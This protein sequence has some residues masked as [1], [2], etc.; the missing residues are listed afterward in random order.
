M[1]YGSICTGVA[2]LDRAVEAVFGALPAWQ[3]EVDK[4]ACKVLARHYP[5]VPNLGDIKTV[6]WSTVE[7]VDILCG[8]PPC[9]PVSQAGL[10]K[11]PDDDRFLWPDVL[12]AVGRLRPRWLVFENPTGFA[13]FLGATLY[14]LAQLGY[15]GSWR[16]LGAADIG[17]CH[18]RDRFFIVAHSSGAGR[19]GDTGDAPAQEEPDRRQPTHGGDFVAGSPDGLSAAHSNGGGCEELGGTSG[20][21]RQTES[22]DDADRSGPRLVTAPDADGLGRDRGRRMLPRG[23]GGLPAS[24][25]DSAPANTDS[26]RREGTRAQGRT[27]DDGSRPDGRDGSFLARMPDGTIRDYGPALRRH[28]AVLGRPWPA[29]TIGRSLNGDFSAWMQFLP[30]GWLDG[31]SNSAKKRL[32]GN[33]VV[34][35]QA[36]VAIHELRARLD[37]LTSVS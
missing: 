29:P 12:D 15:V 4:D 8:G 28:A 22:G 16:V 5:G 30:E 7:P 32:A 17:A 20:Q 14:Q 13:P 19:G 35:L 26:P 11:G 36:A 2:G 37:L 18:Q 9:Q 1:N 10:R 23:R 25:C 33:S 6:D 31:V 24:D 34:W 21:T 3:C 27:P